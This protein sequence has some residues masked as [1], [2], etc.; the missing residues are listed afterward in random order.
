MEEKPLSQESQ[1]EK[2]FINQ[3]WLGERAGKLILLLK[4]LNSQVNRTH[5]RFRLSP[6]QQQLKRVTHE[7]Q[8]SDPQAIFFLHSLWE[9]EDEARRE[10]DP[11]ALD[12]EKKSWWWEDN[13]VQSLL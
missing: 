5:L 2:V 3:D 11:G 13:R 7:E 6:G 1:I 4:M 12:L 8:E 9:V 10:C